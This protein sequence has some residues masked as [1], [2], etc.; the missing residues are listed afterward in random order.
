MY[1]TVGVVPQSLVGLI[2]DQ[3][4]DLSSRTG[5]SRQVIHHH[6]GGQEEHPACPPQLP[7]AASLRAACG[8]G[9]TDLVHVCVL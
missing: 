8:G 1:L 2:D 7:P 3:T 4:L 5:F 9:G 6:L